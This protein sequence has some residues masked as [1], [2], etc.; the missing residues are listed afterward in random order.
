M[1]YRRAEAKDISILIELR[2]KQLIDEGLAPINN[3]D[4]ELQSY[5][6]ASLADGSLISWIAEEEGAIVATSGICFYQLPP[7]YL[8]PS[9]KTAYVTNMYTQDEYRRKGIASDLLSLVVEEARRQNYKVVRLHASEQGRPVYKRY[10]F[11]DS[12]GNMVMH[13]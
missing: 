3:I 7:S 5:F 6:E 4:A 9:G 11:K 10:G 12:E 2:K 8:N 1:N 13:L